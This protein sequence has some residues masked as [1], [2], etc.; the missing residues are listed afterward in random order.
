[1]AS[2]GLGVVDLDTLNE[3]HD[4]AVDLDEHV[5]VDSDDGVKLV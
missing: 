2:E 5:D 4:E 1:M 3:V